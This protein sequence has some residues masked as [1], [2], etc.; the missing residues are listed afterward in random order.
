MAK[1]PYS[2]YLTVLG[3][4]GLDKKESLESNLHVY[5]GDGTKIVVYS[6]G[7]CPKEKDRKK[8]RNLCKNTMNSCSFVQV[9]DIIT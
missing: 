2:Y 9:L 4:V 7:R 8:S 3:G 1:Q 5:D 6:M